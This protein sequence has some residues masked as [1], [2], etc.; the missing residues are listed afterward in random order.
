MTESI[1]DGEHPFICRTT[2]AT[3][4]SDALSCALGAMLGFVV[5]SGNDFIS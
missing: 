2:R 4:Y 1:F 5:L 3:Q